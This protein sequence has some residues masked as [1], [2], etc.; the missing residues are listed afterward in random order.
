MFISQTMFDSDVTNQTNQMLVFWCNER[1]ITMQSQL[2][3]EYFQIMIEAEWSIF[4]QNYKTHY[5]H[6]C[7]DF[8]MYV[9][10]NDIKFHIFLKVYS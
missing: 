2:T 3:D 8:S 7:Y 5:W 1:Q 4:F 6:D 9:F 10:L